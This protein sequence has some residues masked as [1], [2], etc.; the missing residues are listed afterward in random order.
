[1]NNYQKLL[2]FMKI[3]CQNLGVLHRNLA[4]NEAWFINHEQIDKWQ[5]E[6]EKQLDDLIETGIALG[7]KEPSI[8]ESLL[9]YQ[10]ECLPVIQREAKETFAI[11]L[12]SFRDLSGL[13]QTAEADVPINTQNRLQEYEYF[14][15]KEANYKIKQMLESVKSTSIINTAEED[16]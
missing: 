1:M 5:R 13:M 10:N 14:W 6:T 7:F 4:N 3:L 8:A 9:N 15:N 12:K 16:D 11:L 2:M